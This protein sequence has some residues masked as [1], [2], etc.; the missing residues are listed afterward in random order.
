MYRAMGPILIPAGFLTFCVLGFTKNDYTRW[1]FL[2]PVGI[3]FA[4]WKLLDKFQNWKIVQ[5]KFLNFLFKFIPVSVLVC[6]FAMISAFNEKTTENYMIIVDTIFSVVVIL[7]I[8][9]I[10]DLPIIS[11]VLGYLGKHSMNIFLL[12]NFLRVRWCPAHVFSFRHFALIV[13]ML[14]LESLLMSVV[15]EFVKKHSGYNRLVKKI[16]ARI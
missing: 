4:D 11:R 15:L 9:F 8:C 5:N 10:K 7:W 2:L 6:V 16:Y 3:W 13:V 1:I 12:H 14:L